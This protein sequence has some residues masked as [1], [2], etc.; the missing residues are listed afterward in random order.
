MQKIIVS[1]AVFTASGISMLQAE[2]KEVS[3]SE[4]ALSYAV[5]FSNPTTTDG[6]KHG[7]DISNASS[8]YSMDKIG[9][10]PDSDSDTG[11]WKCIA[12]SESAMKWK[13]VALKSTPLA[14]TIDGGLTEKPKTPLGSGTDTW[15]PDKKAFKVKVPAETVLSWNNFISS[16]D[17]LNNTKR[18]IIAA[19][20]PV[21]FS[22]KNSHLGNPVWTTTGGCFRT[23]AET[24]AVKSINNETNVTWFAPK[25]PGLHTITIT[26]PKSGL[27]KKADSS[28]EFDTNNG[29]AII[30]FD[31][32]LPE[33]VSVTKINETG[34][35]SGTINSQDAAATTW[36]GVKMKLRYIAAPRNVNYSW[37]LT[38]EGTAPPIFPEQTSPNYFKI[39]H[40]LS[41][42]NTR[43]R[44]LTHKPAS[45]NDKP[46]WI[47]LNENGEYDDMAGY[48]Q[49][50]CLLP[51]NG[52]PPYWTSGSY[53][54]DIP[55]YF[56][57]NDEMNPTLFRTSNDEPTNKFILKQQ[58][59]IE[60]GPNPGIVGSG[61][62]AVTL[63]CTKNSN[64]P[65]EAPAKVEKTM[66]I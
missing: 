37:M 66:S 41:T 60:S 21:I 24:P 56:R 40:E 23:S 25:E 28:G 7:I 15:T 3:V 42:Q 52:D 57:G 54:W 61:T 27:I 53:H 12:S 22:V 33:T 47:Q 63:K 10:S 9:V 8:K 29:V 11:S 18:K 39:T 58:F 49:A 48:P 5:N 38:A 16:H 51:D 31:I 45:V 1:G 19:G 59:N 26:F 32:R 36:I 64:T 50:D 17:E 55:V 13:I 43:Q 6:V 2:T 44:D 65:G 30:I 4:S 46:V 35:G 14:Y 34:T 20:E 62:T